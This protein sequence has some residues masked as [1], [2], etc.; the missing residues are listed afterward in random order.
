MN[1]LEVFSSPS[2]SSN[3]VSDA[4]QRLDRSEPERYLVEWSGE[5]MDY[6]SAY[7]VRQIGFGRGGRPVLEIEGRRGGEYVIDSNPSGTPRVEY[8]PPNGSPREER[9]RMLK[10]YDTKFEWKHWIL[11]RLGI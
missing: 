1:E 7:E 5:T 4:I 11:Q 6:A 8:R 10:I 2:P 3:G 9:L